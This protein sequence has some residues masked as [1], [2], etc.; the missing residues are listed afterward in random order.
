M[1]RYRMVSLLGGLALLGLGGLLPLL[2]PAQQEWADLVLLGGALLLLVALYTYAATIRRALSRRS[3]RYGLQATL[4]VLLVFGILVL[5]E[6]I[7]VGHSFRL[8]LSEGRRHSLSEQ[9]QKVLT[10]LPVEVQVTAFYRTD[11]PERREARDLFRLYAALSPRFRYELADPDRNPGLVKRYEIAAYGTTVLAT[12]EKEERIYE[13]DEERLTNALL[14]VTRKGKAVVY[15]L[16]GHGEAGFKDFSP[17]GLSGI[18]LEI[19][20]ANYEAREL[21]LLRERKVPDDAAVLIVAGPRVDPVEAEIASFREYVERGGRV[22][23][24][25]DPFTAPGL[26][27]FLEGYGIRVGNNVILDRMSRVFGA[28]PLLPVISTYHPHPITRN[29]ALATLF[30]YC[31]SVEAV[32]KPPSGVAL[33][34]LAESGAFPGSWAETDRAGLERGE[35]TFDEGRDLKGPVGIG[36]AATLPPAKGDLPDASPPRGKGRLVVYGTSAFI[37]NNF[38]GFAG[39]KDLFLNTLGWLAGEEDLIVIRPREAKMAPLVLTAAQGRVVFWLPVVA[40][41]LA[42]VAVGAIVL[43]RRR[44]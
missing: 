25:V 11:Q 31:R 5:V 1:K 16:K 24:L 18:R 38:L 30:P 28:D 44:R 37:R 8:D 23:F 29:F 42:I 34:K 39:N 13:A 14:R 4:I 7:S 15:F 22:L 41:P 43:L 3:T 26:V 12:R 10:N 20:K 19:E 40:S 9:T 2:F 35:S 21:L 27:R 33:Q 6:A 36:L 17:A 32:E